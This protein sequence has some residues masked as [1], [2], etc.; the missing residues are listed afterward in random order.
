[1]CPMVSS[2]VDAFLCTFICTGINYWAFSM[3]PLHHHQ[4]A[5]QTHKRAC[6]LID[7][8]NHWVTFGATFQLFSAHKPK[9]PQASR[10]TKMHLSQHH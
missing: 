9:Q 8:F 1:M 10:T 6:K 4:S 2:S 3:S 5:L 7:Y